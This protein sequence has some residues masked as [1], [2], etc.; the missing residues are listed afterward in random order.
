[1]AA[2]KKALKDIRTKIGDRE[3]QS[4]LYDAQTLLQSLSNGDADIPTVC[5]RLVNK[6]PARARTQCQL[7]GRTGSGFGPKRCPLLRPSRRRIVH[8]L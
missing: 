5:V 3:P 6:L 4:A 8:F 7:G 2:T 1:M